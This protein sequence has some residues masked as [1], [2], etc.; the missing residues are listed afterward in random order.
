MRSVQDWYHRKVF[1][2]GF[3]DD[4]PHFGPVLARI[5]AY[6]DPHCLMAVS[7]GAGSRVR[8]HVNTVAF[9]DQPAA[10]RAVLQHELHHVIAGHLDPA[11]HQVSEPGIMQVAKEITAN[12]NIVEPLPG[13]PHRWHSY[14]KFGI[15]PGQTT[16]RR[17]ELLVAA[18]DAGRYEPPPTIKVLCCAPREGDEL[19]ET[20]DLPEHMQRAM[21]R[22]LAHN[23]AELTIG[24]ATQQPAI[25]WARELH[26]FAWSRVER[27]QTLRR[28][29][30]RDPAC[31]RIGEVPGW[32]RLLAR[33]R[34]LV[35]IDTSGSMDK[36]LFPRIA[37]E[38]SAMARR[39]D[40]VIVECDSTIQREYAFRGELQSVRGRGDTDLRPV[41]EPEVRARHRVDGVVYFTDGGGPFPAANP[42]IKTLWVLSGDR[43]FECEWGA[44]VYMDGRALS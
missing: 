3:L 26:R 40:L 27:R 8:L 5:D 24:A 41:F 36:G 18:R 43:P 30:R 42:G 25:D 6:E 7:P 2:T 44:R 21:Q 13:S 10:F 29:S 32:S 19:G 11:Y 14:A 39:A 35:A 16:W 9:A 1:E 31:K 15:R 4:Y 22:A 28:P 20:I 12:E 17:Y 37:G 34:L 23:P 38:L 33:S